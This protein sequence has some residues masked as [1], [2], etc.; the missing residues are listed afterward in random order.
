M[1]PGKTLQLISKILNLKGG[2]FLRT[3]QCF[4]CQQRLSLRYHFNILFEI[5]LC[6]KGVL[7]L[8]WRSSQKMLV[9]LGSLTLRLQPDS[10]GKEAPPFLSCVP[11]FFLSCLILSTGRERGNLKRR[12]GSR[13][14]SDGSLRAG[15]TLS[16]VLVAWRWVSSYGIRLVE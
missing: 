5:F 16:W 3:S 13:Q 14:D 8:C 10:K 12:R 4:Y 11:R 9:V 15:V 6:I 1:C 2:A 7:S